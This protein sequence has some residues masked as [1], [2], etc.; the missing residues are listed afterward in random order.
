[1]GV[2]VTGGSGMLGRV[3]MDALSLDGGTRGVSRGGAHGTFACDLTDPRQVENFFSL[4]SFDLVVHTAAYSDVDGCERNPKLAHASNAVSTKYL[5]QACGQK[6]TPF[7]YISTDYVF[8]GTMKALVQE[9]DTPC[10]INIYGMTKLE[11]EVHN[12]QWAPVS[13]IVRTSWLFGPGNPANFVNA[14]AERL[15]KEKV[16]R[17]LADQE[18][19][20]T[21]VRDLSVAIQKIAN[22]L[23]SLSKKGP[24][25]NYQGIFHVCNAGETT[26]YEMASKI[27]E[28]LGLKEVMIEKLDKLPSES[29]PAL[30]PKYASMSTKHYETF[31][32]TKLRRWEDSLK[33][34]LSGWA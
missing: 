23:L 19:R 22:Y 1:M 25:E 30:R 7:I 31:F 26:R 33:E 2:L 5:A 32:K 21:Y 16:V 24:E 29:R 17:V 6:R 20:P 18:N 15:R 14:V 27:R 4:N 28:Y 8:D 12:M 34:Y 10:P 13:A 11:G 9:N 3:L